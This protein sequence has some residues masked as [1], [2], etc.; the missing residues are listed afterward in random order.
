M[1]NK[2]TTSKKI[3]TLAS[4]TLK[5]PKASKIKKKLAASA[6]SQ[7]NKH[8]QTGSS[9]E[10]V[11]SEVLRSEKYSKETHALAATVLSQSN[12]DR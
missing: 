9:M 8:N 10:S 3:S 1:K 4:K 12:K 11:A 6:L 5:D 7:S 2:K